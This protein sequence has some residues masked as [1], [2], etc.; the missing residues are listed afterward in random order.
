MLGIDPAAVHFDVEDPAPARNQFGFNAFR[1]PDRIRQ[2]GGFGQ[3]V[4]LC[5]VCD[6]DLH[7]VKPPLLT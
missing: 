6:A 2:T 3:V 5:A 4:S 7:R 1:V